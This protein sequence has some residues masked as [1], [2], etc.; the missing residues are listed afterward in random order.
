MS[1]AEGEN[2]ALIGRQPKII[3]FDF[4]VFAFSFC[5][6]KISSKKKHYRGREQE[7]SYTKSI[8]TPK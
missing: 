8:K 7:K 4:C 5:I 6:I 1:L 2:I 3:L